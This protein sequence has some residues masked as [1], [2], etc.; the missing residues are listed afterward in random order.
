MAYLVNVL[1]IVFCLCVC[2]RG[3]RMG[4]DY[5]SSRGPPPMRSRRDDYDDRRR[6]GGGGYG[7]GG[8]G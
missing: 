1:D 2:T 5:R 7:G 6:S 4:G 3:S 8:G